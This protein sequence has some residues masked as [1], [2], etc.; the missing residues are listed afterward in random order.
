M[1]E[2]DFTAEIEM[3]PVP[4]QR[5]RAT[6][7]GPGGHIR[8]YTPKRT[9]DAQDIIYLSLQDQKPKEPFA[10]P[11][12]VRVLFYMMRPNWHY[13]KNGE[14]RKTAPTWPISRRVGDLDNFQKTVLDACNKVLFDD[15]CQVCKIYAVK[16][17][18]DNCS[19]RVIIS[20]RQLIESP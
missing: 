18:A 14:L 8:M 7:F 2:Y 11:L 15:D 13:K 19:P 4:K 6:R 1:E 16:S 12:Q 17:Y 10:G 3:D 20:V 5:P 9:H